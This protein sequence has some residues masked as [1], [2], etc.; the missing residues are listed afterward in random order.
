MSS[1]PSNALASEL[2]ERRGLRHELVQPIDLDRVERRD[3]NHLL[4]QH[5]ERISR[6]QR[7]FDGALQH[8]LDRRRAGQQ[9]AAVLRKDR[10]RGSP[11]RRCGPRARCA[12]APTRPRAALR[13]ASPD[14]PRPCRCR[15]RARTSRRSPAARRSS[16]GPRSAARRSR[17]IEPWCASAISS[18]ASSFSAAASRSASRRLLTKIIVERC[19]RISSTRRGWI[20]GQIE[21]RARVAARSPGLD[22]VAVA[23]RSATGTST[24]NLERLLG[25]GVD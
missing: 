9:I 2:G 8:A 1:T 15:A 14:R 16:A 17:A 5:V 3:R 6:V 24:R 19:A 10:C 23:A 13:S 7:G 4:R 12:A 22:V 20:D 25:A 11:R 21:A 18:S